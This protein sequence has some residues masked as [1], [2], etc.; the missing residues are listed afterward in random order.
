MIHR[1]GYFYGFALAVLLSCT[2]QS[3]VSA[4]G[5]IL[6][7]APQPAF[8]LKKVEPPAV[9]QAGPAPGNAILIE[10]RKRRGQAP[11]RAPRTISRTF[12]RGE[13]PECVQAAVAGVPTPTQCD[14]KTRW[15]DGTLRHVLVSFWA[16]LGDG[17]HAQVDFLPHECDEGATGLDREAMLS[18]MGGRWDPVLEVNGLSGDGTD[19]GF[20]AKA[21]AILSRWD[22]SESA[23]GVRYW[24]KGPIATQVIVEDKSVETRED[25]GWKSSLPSTTLDVG[26]PVAAMTLKT[27]AADDTVLRQWQFPMYVAV[28]QEVLQ[29]CGYEGVTL[30]VCPGGRGAFGTRPV[31]LG[32]ASGIVPLTGWTRAPEKSH[33]SLH[34]IWVLTFY[35]GWEGVRVETI[36]ENVWLDRVQDQFYGF[37]IL[38]E[39]E[40]SPAVYEKGAI[41]HNFGARWRKSHWVG[42]E[43]APVRIDHNL[44]YLIHSRVVPNYDLS[45]KMAQSAIVA[46]MKNFNASDRGEPGGT[47]LWQPNM[48][49]A[50]GR[51]D[52]GLIPGLY[53]AYMYTWD[54]SMQD[55]F[56]GMAAASGHVPIHLRETPGSERRFTPYD[57]TPAAGRVVSVDARP[58][59]FA[60]GTAPYTRQETRPQDAA[61][62]AVGPVRRSIWTPDAAHQPE[63]AYLPYAL[64]GDW[65]YLEELQFWSALALA[66]GNPSQCNWCRHG[67]MGLLTGQS[68]AQAWTFRTLAM[69]VAITPDATPEKTYFL[70]KFQNNIAVREGAQDIQDGHFYEPAPD[71]AKP[72]RDTR[73]RLGRDIYG[74]AD[75]N[76]LQYFERGG[77]AFVDGSMDKTKVSGAASPWMMNFFHMSM[78]MAEE[79]GLGEV[80][81][82]RRFFAANLIWQLQHP[83]FNPYLAAAYRIPTYD[84]EGKYFQTW[85]AVLDAYIPQFQTQ[86]N[87]ASGSEDCAEC[88]SNM[89]RGTSSWLVGLTTPDGMSGTEAFLWIYGKMPGRKALV[90]DPKY[91]YLP[92]NPPE[93]FTA[94]TAQARNPGWYK[95]ELTKLALG[96][97]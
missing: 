70:A 97:R 90:N 54:P 39:G 24:M 59:F 85:A 11:A 93:G 15:P 38:L 27:R 58:T 33:R 16:E 66:T 91:A 28:Q 96:R 48:P 36:V 95:L 92:R 63:M 69:T 75:R 6:P 52:L 60:Y 43:P 12:A 26:T 71:C 46:Q 5:P 45:I 87:W 2:T 14:V 53:V 34:P 83:D 72:C 44:P 67:S 74:T 73:W 23:D 31:V 81:G 57:E 79:L 4:E 61:S 64:M 84:P 68:R 32:A 51:Q 89:A 7:T 37:R 94:G 50:G 30:T 35:P 62:A 42:H 1:R 86:K 25:F 76:T 8:P 77:T 82:I 13:F 56:E 18:F 88:Y 65:Y 80:S 20:R 3:P 49:A 22:G 21:R 55:L 40:K 17:G 78:G 29:V 9:G 10:D 19:V 41:V 47:A